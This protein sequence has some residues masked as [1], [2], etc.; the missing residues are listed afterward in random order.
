MS[1]SGRP[2]EREEPP[3]VVRCGGDQRSRLSLAGRSSI[4]GEED[5]TGNWL[6]RL[7]VLGWLT[8][9]IE[10]SGDA[11]ETGGKAPGGGGEGKKGG[12][13]GK[14]KGGPPGLVKPSIADT[15]K[16]NVYA[17]NWFMLYVN[18]RLVAVDP[19]TARYT[20][21]TAKR[22]NIEHDTAR[23]Q[24]YLAV[25][26]D[27]VGINVTAN[28]KEGGISANAQPFREAVADFRADA[29]CPSSDADFV[30]LMTSIKF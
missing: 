3:P 7:R 17:D 9:L 27:V 11:G 23:L 13:K 8:R 16:L 30:Y 24:F 29:Q 5:G 1:L 22:I 20:E 26:G 6:V 12:G 14:G 10:D 25:I 19:K 2:I 15:M 28:A 18:G 21:T 4:P